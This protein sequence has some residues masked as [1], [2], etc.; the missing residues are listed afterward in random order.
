[1]GKVRE[2]QGKR[3][4][5]FHS[6][7]TKLLWIF[8]RGRTD[9]ATDISFLFTRLKYPVVEYCKNLQRLLCFIDQKINDDRI[10]GENY[11]QKMQTYVVSSHAV[12][13]DMGGH[14]GGVNTFFVGVLMSNPSKQNMRLIIPKKPEVIENS[15][16]LPYDI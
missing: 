13:M 16:Y 15:E 10:I 12:H 14:K 7:F 8:Q 4:Y 1:M 5:T 6:V 9:C 3:L 11:P 2:L